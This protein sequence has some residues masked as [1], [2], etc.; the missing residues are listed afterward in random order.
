M[1]NI[2]IPKIFH[3]LWFG[4]KPIPEQ[5]QRWI[6]GWLTLHPGWEHKIWTDVNRPTFTNEAQ[7]LAADN[8]SLKANVARYE[9]V[10]RHGGIYLDTDFECL[11]SLEPLLG[12][13]EAFIASEE[14][15]SLKKLNVSIFG[16]TAGHPWLAELIARL[17]R[18]MET[19]WGNQHQA[20]PVFA[21]YVTVGR[22]DVTVFPERLFQH[23]ERTP[24]PET[25]AIHHGAGSW[26]EAGRA[27][28][29][30]KV[31]QFVTEDIERIVPL[32]S[33]FILVNKG[34]SIETSGRRS[35]PFPERDGEWAG[36]PAD[37]ASAI[38]ELQRLRKT[39]AEFIVFPAPMFYWL[40]SY[41]GFREYLSAETRCVR[42]NERALI[43]DLRA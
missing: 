26:G 29:E 7:F 25:Y 37:D 35:V 33:L 14:P 28:F 43:F 17:P 21:R 22:P 8:F 19:G 31:R 30:A 18:A 20:G 9:I 4:S 24:F 41:P 40:D 16:A 13:V 42:S 3:W 5:H 6:E 12:D 32:G 10:Y 15:D 23:E 38:A 27:K 2:R 36:Y 1:T 39:G 11:R 34:R